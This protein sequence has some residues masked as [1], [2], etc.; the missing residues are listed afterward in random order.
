MVMLNVVGRKNGPVPDV[1]SQVMRAA[2]ARGFKNG[3]QIRGPGGKRGDKI[4][5]WLSDT[6]FVVNAAST[7]KNLG[8][9]SA[10]N[11]GVPVEAIMGTAMNA[12][13]EMSVAFNGG[14]WGYA[15]TGKIIGDSAAKSLVNRFGDAGVA[16]EEFQVAFD[17]GDWGYGATS[18]FVGEDAARM[19][20]NAAGSA[21]EMVGPNSN[22]AISVEELTTAFDG[23]DWGYG[24]LSN[25]LGEERARVAVNTAADL[26][27]AVRGSQSAARESQQTVNNFMAANPEEMYRMYRRE[28]ARGAHGKVGAR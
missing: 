2:G 1:V 17:G 8:L 15:S 26:G 7:A 6:E 13:E 3:G 19:L 22:A 25:F 14:D 28:T 21:G 5:A 9:L 20:V 23:G 10:M 27:D 4:P 16:A 24:A 18:S 12:A 11:S